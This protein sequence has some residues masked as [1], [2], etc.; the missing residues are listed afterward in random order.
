VRAHT[1]RLFFCALF[2]ISDQAFFVFGQLL[3]FISGN[4]LG[5]HKQLTTGN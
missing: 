2:F 3:L 4:S 1:G 5:E